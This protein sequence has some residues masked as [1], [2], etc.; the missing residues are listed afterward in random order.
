MRDNRERKMANDRLFIVRTSDGEEIGPVDQQTVVKLAESGRINLESKIRSTLVNKWEPA[1][2]LDAIKPILKAQLQTRVEQ[3]NNTTWNKIKARI[4]LKV[5][6][7]DDGKTSGLVRMDPASA[8]NASLG[9]RVCAAITDWLILAAWFVVLYLIFAWMFAHKIIGGD[10]IFYIGFLIYW[11]T[12]LLYFI[13]NIAI[14]SQTPGQ[15][16]WGIY[17]VCR[18]GDNLWIGRIFFYTLFMLLFGIF[19]PLFIYATPS[20]KTCQEILTKTRMA[21]ILLQNKKA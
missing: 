9:L 19:S 4:N 3:K 18:D 21:R 11:T 5:R 13:L 2:E 16:F 1:I 7:M 15:R 17:L 8:P 10:S 20:A 12:L 14:T 6:K